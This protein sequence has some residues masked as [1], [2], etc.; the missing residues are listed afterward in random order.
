MPLSVLLAPLRALL[1]ANLSSPPPSPPH[2]P[3][4]LHPCSPYTVL[5]P[6]MV[7]LRGW[8]SQAQQAEIVGA[9]RVLGMGP[10]GFYQPSYSTG[11]QLSL[12]MM[13]LGMHWEPRTASYEQVR[14]RGRGYP[15]Y[16]HLGGCCPLAR[17]WLAWQRPPGHRCLSA[18]LVGLGLC[19]C[20]VVHLGGSWSSCLC[21]ALLQAGMAQRRDKSHSGTSLR[22]LVNL[23]H[24]VTL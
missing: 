7:L 13:G 4:P 24:K 14:G 21:L 20:A 8:L 23:E 10:G 11:G 15:L 17:L 18:L 12:K 6:G 22:Q 2:P 9:V 16:G 19:A 1:T 3:L 5:Q